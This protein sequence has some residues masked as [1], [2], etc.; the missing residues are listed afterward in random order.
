[1]VLDFKMA[2]MDPT[3]NDTMTRVQLRQIRQVRIAYFQVN[4]LILF[5]PGY[6]GIIV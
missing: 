5:Q 1:M 6:I 2:T 3:I 4:L